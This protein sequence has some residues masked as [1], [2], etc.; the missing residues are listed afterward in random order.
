MLNLKVF[1]DIYGVLG[2]NHKPPLQLEQM[3]VSPLQELNLEVKV[4]HDRAR[5][6]G[7]ASGL[8][9]REVLGN[10][11]LTQAHREC[12]EFREVWNAAQ[13]LCFARREPLRIMSEI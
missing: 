5:R 3:R 13:N 8:V 11:G 1:A 9:L 12:M 7:F 4:S 2:F 6:V 10:L